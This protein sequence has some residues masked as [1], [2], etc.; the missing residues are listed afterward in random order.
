MRVDDAPRVDSDDRRRRSAVWDLMD[1]DNREAP[2]RVKA[3]SQIARRSRDNA[4]AVNFELDPHI[5]HPPAE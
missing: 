2:R 1:F 3:R 5:S 4:C